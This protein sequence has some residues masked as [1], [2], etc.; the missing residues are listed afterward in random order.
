MRT[1]WLK[2]GLLLLLAASILLMLG[3]VWQVIAINR[4]QAA[5]THAVLTDYAALVAEQYE[6]RLVSTFGLNLIY[7]LL[8][9]DSGANGDPV[10]A[11]AL[12]QAGDIP[13]RFVLRAVSAR[14]T[15]RAGVVSLHAGEV[16]RAWMVELP[17]AL[18]SCADREDTARG[19]SVCHAPIADT[20]A[21]IVFLSAAEHDGSEWRVA[22]IDAT[23]L[24]DFFAAVFHQASLFPEALAGGRLGN[25]G[26]HLRLVDPAGRAR[27]ETGPSDPERPASSRRLQG[28]YSG[29][30]R[31]Y[32]VEV[33]LDPRLSEALIIGGLP[34]SRLPLLA[35]MIVLN[36]LV[37]LALVRL[38]YREQQLLQLRGDFIAR[39]SHE[40]RTPL[41]QIR[42]F[43]ESLLLG[44][45]RTAEQRNR[46]MQVIR[47]ESLRLGQLVD[48]LLDFSSRRQSPD[49][50]PQRLNLKEELTGIVEDFLP[51]AAPH[52]ARIDLKVQDDL[53]WTLD[54]DAL[55][56]ILTNLLDNA[57][58][59]GPHGQTI[60]VSSKYN[61][62]ELV[63]AV[64]DQGPGIPA[65]LQKRIW[66]D[67]YRLPG[68]AV[69]T[70]AGTGIG[71][72]VV[73]DLVR[74]LG[75]KVSVEKGVDSDDESHGAVFLIRLPESVG[76]GTHTDH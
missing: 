46:A 25:D 40:L 9:A 6:R 13:A 34:G 18:A 55:R 42:L 20:D 31:D 35:V 10:H 22:L 57:V 60:T 45:V 54:R 5:M 50:H 59:Y 70:I 14:L 69:M 12:N 19:I 16:S 3:L 61:D 71:L 39:V 76:D 24:S 63:L 37:S 56:Q 66:E 7:R 65:A 36:L 58:K 41:T 11:T 62:R 29:L 26:I 67:Y 51:L 8:Q 15:Y 4:S 64:A 47:R 23:A 38:L 49:L 48:N 2:Y 30:F 74:I 53:Y 33:S 21:V 75:G 43:A 44:R 72:A 68:E 28:D 32:T 73:H 1:S 27:Y 17:Q 52:E